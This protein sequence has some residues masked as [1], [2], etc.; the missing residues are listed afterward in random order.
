[1]LVSDEEATLLGPSF[2][3]QRP[4]D[5]SQVVVDEMAVISARSEHTL[6]FKGPPLQEGS[7][8]VCYSF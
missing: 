4:L 6:S 8:S 2:K 3:R 7:N 5:R 1:M